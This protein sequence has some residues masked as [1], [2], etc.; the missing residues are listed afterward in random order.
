MHQRVPSIPVTFFFVN[1]AAESQIQIM[2][3][4]NEGMQYAFFSMAC[5]NVT[6]SKMYNG[7]ISEGTIQLSCLSNIVTK[8][9][10][11]LC[12]FKYRLRIMTLQVVEEKKDMSHFSIGSNNKK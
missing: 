10:S 6:T 8:K 7:R 11:I 4:V 1:I 2:G 5:L 9:T 3:D 12:N